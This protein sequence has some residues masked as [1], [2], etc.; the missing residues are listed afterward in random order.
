MAE[1]LSQRR[2]QHLGPPYFRQPIMLLSASH[3]QRR[4]VMTRLSLPSSTIMYTNL[5]NQIKPRSSASV[6]SFLLRMMKATLIARRNFCLSV[7][8]STFL[9]AIRR[10]VSTK[11]GLTTCYMIRH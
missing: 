6:K 7:N 5:V 11:V 8:L 4:T 2:L 3:Q 1:S 10:E 9:V